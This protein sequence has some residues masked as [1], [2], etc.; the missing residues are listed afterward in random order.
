MSK[1]NKEWH[2]AHPMDKNPTT[3]ERLT[4]HLEHTAECGC[5]PIP[6]SLLSIMA[7]RGIAM[8]ERGRAE[9]AVDQTAE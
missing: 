1:L 8:P 4:W 7:Q 5:R 9:Q 2:A 6:A 3:E